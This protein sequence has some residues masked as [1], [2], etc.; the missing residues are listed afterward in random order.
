MGLM[1]RSIVQLASEPGAEREEMGRAWYALYVAHQHEKR[2]AESLAAKRIEAFLPLY[3]EVRQWSD[4][5][6]W[7]S[8]P[9]FPCYVFV[10]SGLEHRMEMLTIPGVRGYVSF[11]SR[12]AEIPA[13]EIDALRRAVAHSKIEPHPFLRDGDW[14]RVKSGVF[15]GIEGILVRRKGET[16]LVLSVEMLRKSA[17]IEIDAAQTEKIWGMKP[18]AREQYANS[19]APRTGA[20]GWERIA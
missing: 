2:V 7:V 19:Y 14:V 6:K 1:G 18:M 11:D 12:P 17:S 3:R 13:S 10:E 16:R 8:V 4:R 15:A 9:L 20:A 5:R